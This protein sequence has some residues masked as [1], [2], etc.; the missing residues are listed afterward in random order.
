MMHKVPPPLFPVGTRVK[1]LM[2]HDEGHMN[3]TGEVREA[4][5]V[6]AYGVLV[7]GMEDQGIH[8]W[9]IESELAEEGAGEGE[10]MDMSDGESEHVRRKLTETFRKLLDPRQ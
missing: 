7:D 8:H 4:V 1:I 6:Y 10:A 2:P 3:A 5:L 9:Y